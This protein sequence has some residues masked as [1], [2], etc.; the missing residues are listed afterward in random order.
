MMPITDKDVDAIVAK[1][2][3]TT[4]NSRARQTSSSKKKRLVYS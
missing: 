2:M 3:S 1:L 4:T